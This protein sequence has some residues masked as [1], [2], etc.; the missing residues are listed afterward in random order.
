MSAYP[1]VRCG[2][3]HAD[4]S[5]TALYQRLRRVPP[6][7][8]EVASRAFWRT[9]RFA[10]PF[11]RPSL[12]K[13]ASTQVRRRRSV[14]PSPTP[15]RFF[16]QVLSKHCTSFRFNVMSAGKAAPVASLV[17]SAASYPHA[18]NINQSM[19]LR[20]LLKLRFFDLKAFES[21]C[22]N[23]GQSDTRIRLGPRQIDL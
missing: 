21:C 6:C 12:A 3:S 9:K 5:G 13:P 15:S 16:S 18:G 2:A 20:N 14:S 4:F 8:G 7:S 10:P 23:T 22:V 11:V 1:Y 17:K 19:V